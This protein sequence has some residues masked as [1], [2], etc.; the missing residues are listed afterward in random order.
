M[1][2]LV[3]KLFNDTYSSQLLF[4]FHQPNQKTYTYV[5]RIATVTSYMFRK[6]TKH[7]FPENNNEGIG[8]YDIL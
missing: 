4:N 2:A 3:F 1:S 8:M 7:T 6:V 5:R